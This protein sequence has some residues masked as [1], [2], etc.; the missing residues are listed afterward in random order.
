[1]K[2]PGGWIALYAPA[3]SPSKT[4]ILASEKFIVL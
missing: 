2:E 3:L 4:W 1:M